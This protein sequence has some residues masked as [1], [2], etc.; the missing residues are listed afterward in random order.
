MCRRLAVRCFSWIICLFRLTICQWVRLL[1]VH[2]NVYKS[3][4]QWGSQKAHEHSLKSKQAMPIYFYNWATDST[5]LHSYSLDYAH[6]HRCYKE[7]YAALC[8]MN[9]LVS[10]EIFWWTKVEHRWKYWKGDENNQEITTLREN[11]LNQVIIFTLCP[12]WGQ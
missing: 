10:Y 3:Q 12:F 4:S 7:Y 8:C 2:S 11:M 1:L 5:T 6:K 9:C